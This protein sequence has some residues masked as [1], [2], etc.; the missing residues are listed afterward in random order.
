MTNQEKK[1]LRKEV[2]VS[3][4]EIDKDILYLEAVTKPVSPENAIGRISRMDAINNMN[5]NKS[6][7]RSKMEQKQKLEI[8]LNKI[9]EEAFGMCTRCKE[10]IPY[11]RILSVPNSTMCVPC[12]RSL[13]G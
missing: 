10:D 8:V 3:L 7:L 4:E 11:K 12:I 13:K 2:H 5:I 9:D 6:L 1:K